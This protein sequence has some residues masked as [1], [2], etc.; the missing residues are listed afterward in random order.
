VLK[1]LQDEK[2]SLHSRL[3]VS[4][5][6]HSEK[7][8][9]MTAMVNMQATVA[10]KL[11][12]AEAQ[13]EVTRTQLEAL[14]IEMSTRPTLS[15]KNIDEATSKLREEIQQLQAERDRTTG[16]FSTAKADWEQ[17]RASMRRASADTFTLLEKQ[18]QDAKAEIEVVKSEKGALQTKLSEQREQLLAEVA[19]HA[20][21][22]NTQFVAFRK[23]LDE[24]IAAKEEAEG[25]A[26]SV[27]KDLEIQA[28]E[29][30]T[31]RSKITQLEGQLT[32]TNESK[33]ALQ[34]QHK[35]KVAEIDSINAKSSQLE[36]SLSQAQ[37]ELQEAAQQLKTAIG[38]RDAIVEQKKAL[39]LERDSLVSQSAQRESDTS[40][41]IQQVEQQRTLL[42]EQF[43]KVTKEK[44][45]KVKKLKT[46]KTKLTKTQE[47][48]K[49]LQQEATGSKEQIVQHKAKI[50]VL[51]GEV[52]SQV[53]ALS[54]VSQDRDSLVTRL[55]DIK[56]NSDKV[57]E[58]LITMEHERDELMKYRE[59]YEGETVAHA[60]A[61]SLVDSLQDKVKV[62]EASVQSGLIQ[63]E[64][65]QKEA[66][67]MKAKFQAELAVSA[68]EVEKLKA[69]IPMME[70]RIS[71][72]KEQ[73]ERERA[74]TKE[75]ERDLDLEKDKTLQ[76]STAKKDL[77]ETLENTT[78]LLTT[79]LQEHKTKAQLEA[80]D[81]Q[82]QLGETSSRLSY[83]QSSL[84]ETSTR[85]EQLKQTHA[86]VL[87]EKEAMAAEHAEKND[88]FEKSSSEALERI[89][90]LEQQV[91]DKEM[92]AKIAEKQNL[93]TIQQLKAQVKTLET[94]TPTS[95]PQKTAVSKSSASSSA[96]GM[97][98][99][100]S[101]GSISNKPRL[102]ASQT[103]IGASSSQNSTGHSRSASTA[104]S[105]SHIRTP[106]S[107]NASSMTYAT[108][109]NATSSVAAPLQA[110][111]GVSVPTDVDAL[112]K[113]IGELTQLNFT[114]AEQLKAA[115]DAKRK[116]EK[117]SRLKSKW[118]QQNSPKLKLL[119]SSQD[120]STTPSRLA[121]SSDANTVSTPTSSSTTATPNKTSNNGTTSTT[122]VTTPKRP[123][124]EQGFFSSLFGSTASPSRP[125]QP[126]PSE[127]Q[128]A[129]TSMLEDTLLQKMQ[130][131]DELKLVSSDVE[132]LQ[133]QN[134]LLMETLVSH[135]IEVPM[136]DHVK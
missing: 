28:L 12:D 102:N 20:D 116:A 86:T 18:I 89:S 3:E 74:K 129:V 78:H 8:A 120:S 128:Q 55:T 33:D 38:E 41:K 87:E 19:A 70:Q 99:S 14:K 119:E 113:R 61:Q 92:E 22:D 82:R 63:L 84:E 71:S 1:A 24:A 47:E 105:S 77:T 30:T 43:D 59:M 83:A 118:I 48:V 67:A 72:I 135:S 27:A 31:S 131:E 112:S 50:E 88:A 95:T 25:K 107:G 49:Q 91:Q 44:A 52:A 81:L 133:K 130:L 104:S 127:R 40:A 85:L 2:L 10:N 124:T 53:V 68:S 123:P 37:R 76:L 54:S 114:L 110:G 65:R 109:S 57:T 51:E 103:G 36:A 15:Q 32:S 21:K 62:L 39:E 56:M 16:E 90:K 66:D 45:E 5:K 111:G 13:L 11:V 4:D 6:S 132:T 46:F 115:E 97:V 23:Q 26:N 75:L 69:E 34:S 7:D 106:S 35:E 29:L 98:N 93:M 64:E 17:E 60:T 42:Q 58:Q 101:S 96:A 121:K 136:I 117:D 73:L 80:E 108:N 126:E 100:A 122:S 134:R 94:T 79:E 125:I 9:K